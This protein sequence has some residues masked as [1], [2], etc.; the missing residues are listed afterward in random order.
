M[1]SVQILCLSFWGR[2]DHGWGGKGVVGVGILLWGLKLIFTGFNVWGL[3]FL[4]GWW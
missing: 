2:R 1:A 4:K 3:G